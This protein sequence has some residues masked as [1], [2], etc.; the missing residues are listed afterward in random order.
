M[1]ALVTA[2]IIPLV[3]LLCTGPLMARLIRARRDDEVASD[4]TPSVTVVTPMFNEGI[5]IRRTIR[6]ILSQDYAGKLDLIVVDDNSTDDSYQHALD[7]ARGEPRVRVLRNEIN[8]GK[9]RSINR[10]VAET[11][12]EIIVSVDSDVEIEPDAVRH[13]VSR[14][15]SPKV[16]AVG[17]RVDIRNKRHSWLTAMQTAKYFF[18]YQVLKS[19]ERAF[20]SVMCLSGC[21]TAYRRSVLVELAPILE[22][23]NI[24]GVPIK[25]GE[26]RFLTRQ[27][28]KAG[29]ETTMTMDAVCRTDAPTTL[30]GYFAQQLRWRRSNIVDYFGGLSHVWRIHPVVAV[31]YYSLFLMFLAYP[32]LLG[33]SLATGQFWPLMTVHLAAMAVLG[34]VYRVMTRKLPAEQRVS[35]AAILPMALVMP[36]TYAILTP[37][38]LL[39]LDS[40]AWETRGHEAP[41]EVEAIE[42]VPVPVVR[43]RRAHVPDGDGALNPIGVSEPLQ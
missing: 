27:I 37:L 28:V 33:Y 30:S 11:R 7:E 40:R 32:V 4:F 3:L 35:A 24:L 34:V 5:G 12:A 8:E 15:T 17:G 20:R 42:P 18:G 43:V 26:D 1:T 2:I 14:F 25:Y 6:S 10:A 36:V 19:L 31:H 21:L 16:A 22:S 23:R 9:R 38:A 13:L 41:E 29:Y 39:T